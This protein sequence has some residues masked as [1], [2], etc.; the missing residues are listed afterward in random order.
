MQVPCTIRT[1]YSCGKVT[2]EENSLVIKTEGVLTGMD[3]DLRITYGPQVGDV[4]A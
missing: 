3:S 1:T 4:Y 2:N